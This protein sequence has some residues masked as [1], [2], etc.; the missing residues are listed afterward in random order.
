MYNKLELNLDIAKSNKERSKENGTLR[1]PSRPIIHANVKTPPRPS[2]RTT[3]INSLSA[4]SFRY[5]RKGC[6]V[7]S[8]W[9]SDNTPMECA[10]FATR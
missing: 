2:P 9:S 1:K 5:W 10:R 3:K 6:Y 7:N 8:F 4:V